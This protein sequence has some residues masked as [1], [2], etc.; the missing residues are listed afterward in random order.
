MDAL[1]RLLEE[2]NSNFRVSEFRLLR[3]TSVITLHQDLSALTGDWHHCELQ[4]L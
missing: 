1:E 3:P 4:I 2:M